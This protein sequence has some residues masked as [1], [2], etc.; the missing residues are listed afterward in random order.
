[1]SVTANQGPLSII[2]HDIDVVSRPELAYAVVDE[3]HNYVTGDLWTGGGDAGFSVTATT[4]AS[5]AYTIL[6]DGDDNDQYFLATTNAIAEFGTG[7][8]VFAARVKLAATATDAVFIGLSSVTTDLIA[9]GGAGMAAD[10][11]GVGFLRKKNEAVWNAVS[12]N[13]TVQVLTASVA[14]SSTSWV[15]LYA[16]YRQKNATTGT[17]KFYVDGINVATHDLPLTSIA[18]AKAIL[19]AKTGAATEASLTVDYF[20]LVSQ[21]A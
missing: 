5:G 7:S 1:M 2:G 19:S 14:P 8:L 6:T 21:R 3:F 17:V 10:W 4:D 12:A 18:K 15:W 11:D 13:S 16:T 9:D 20:K